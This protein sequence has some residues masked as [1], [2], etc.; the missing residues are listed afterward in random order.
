MTRDARR[1]ARVHREG[2]SVSGRRPNNQDAHAFFAPQDPGRLVEKGCLVVVADGMGGHAGGETASRITVDVV[3]ETYARDHDGD[4]RESL[5]RAVKAANLAVWK[6]AQAEPE[7]RGMGTTC[8]AI[9]IRG[10]E[11]TF[12]H[13]GDSRAYLIRDGV[14]SRVTHDHSLAE[15]RARSGETVLAG[16]EDRDSHILTRAVGVEEWVP[17]DAPDAP[18]RIRTGDAFLVCSD[19]LCRVLPDAELLRVVTEI[20][21]P[22]AC[23][24]LVRL[25]LE[26]GSDDNITVEIVQ[27]VRVGGDV[28]P[29]WWQ[30]LLG[31][32][33]A[34]RARKTAKTTSQFIVARST[35]YERRRPSDR[36]E[37][38]ATDRPTDPL[39]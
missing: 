8:T 6:R 22:R 33:G 9:I 30:R 14:I 11:Y 10:D 16:A 15:E 5:V 38:G 36:G 27:V 23:D 37:A 7:L 3:Q 2:R 34:G 13:V 25:A 17:V 20:D 1:P 28:A 29:S 12:A 4:M 31:R 35:P 18:R 21:P 24:E 39:P 19:G 32:L 26:R